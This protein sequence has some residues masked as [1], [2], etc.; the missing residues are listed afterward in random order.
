MARKLALKRLTRSDLTL[1]RWQFE[2]NSAGNQK[3]INLN[4]DVFE[5]LLFPALPTEASAHGGRFA[6]DLFVYGPGR[7][8]ELNLQRKVIKG[9][10]YKNW[11]LNGEFIENPPDEP[12]R[13]NSLS[14]GDFALMEFGGAYYPESAKLC[15]VDATA[16]AALHAACADLIGQRRMIV[17]SE[18]ELD[19]LLEVAGVEDTFPIG[20]TAVEAA[21]ED[22]ALGGLAGIRRLARRTIRTVSKDE[23]KL[24][25]SRAEEI[26]DIGEQFVNDHFQ[27]LRS[28]GT[29]EDFTWVSASSATAPYDFEVVTRGKREVVDVKATIGAFENRLHISMAE[30]IEMAHSESEYFIFR[31]YGIEGS[32][33][34]LR[35][36]DEMRTF[37][38][39]VLSYLGALPAGVTADGISVSP[40]TL[41]F[42][43]ETNIRILED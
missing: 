13:F 23:L 4:R 1:F 7:A 30:L 19:T 10:T 43:P 25:R 31:V 29:I 38:K 16:S 40:D 35:I 21:L 37:A 42:S 24:A 9:G 14:E 36:S 8:P 11:R 17:L 33:A 34:R 27:S 22:A 12:T 2:N 41:S 3:A 15:L 39:H 28:S 32:R 26:G 5:D 18:G 6:L 20:G